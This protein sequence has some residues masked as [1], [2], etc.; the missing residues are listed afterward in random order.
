LVAIAALV[1]GI[2]G[3]VFSWF[4]AVVIGVPLAVIGLILSIVARKNAMATQQPTGMATAGLVVSIIGLVFAI[5]STAA[6]FACVG[7][8]KQKMKDPAFQEQLR[9]QQQ[10]FDKA[11]DQN[12]KEFNDAFKNAVD[13]TQKPGPGA[14]TVPSPTPTPGAMPAPIGGSAPPA[15][16]APAPPPNLPSK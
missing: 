15:L 5:I 14:T 16:P 3:I 8:M 9:K 13:H 2:I 11:Q 1:L 12:N 4:P 6:C 10:E 7:K